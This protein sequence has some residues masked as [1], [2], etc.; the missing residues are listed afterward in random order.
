MPKRLFV[1][2]WKATLTAELAMGGLEL[3]VD[4]AQAAKLV[5]LGTGDYYLLT[6]VAVDVAGAETAWEIVKVTAQAGGVLTIVRAQEGT[7]ANLWPS[8]SRI[9]ARL[10]AG[11]MSTLRDAAGSGGGGG[12]I[13]D[14]P[15]DGLN[16]RRA[17]AW[18][19]LQGGLFRVPK[20]PVGYDL[21]NLP[22]VN[23]SL[24]QAWSADQLR[25][26]PLP[27][28][29]DITVDL[30]RCSVSTAVAG[31]AKLA[32]YSSDADGWPD[33]LLA[34]GA[35]FSTGST[36]VK[37]SALAAPLTLEA[38]KLYWLALHCSA[39]ASFHG[40]SSGGLVIG[41]SGITQYTCV[42]RSTAYAGG[43]PSPFV[44]DPAELASGIYSTLMS[45]R[46]SA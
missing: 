18:K 45:L 24:G 30:L 44:F 2:N 19:R 8:G 28:F 10:T 34:T 31:N 41:G 26:F 13:P 25:L 9:A 32:L 4:A 5:G 15:D 3:S 23:T 29:D 38:G 14:A 33:V 43:L 39:G 40:L 42:R 7:V 35:E 21:V 1:N 20:P 27:V 17:G 6:L 12:G 11:D 36:G 16:A 22:Q 37:A 46:R